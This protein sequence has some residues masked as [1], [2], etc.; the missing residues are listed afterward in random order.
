MRKVL[1][2]RLT[3]GPRLVRDNRT[4][5]A[6]FINAY[7]VNSYSIL[8]YG[9]RPVPGFDNAS[10]FAALNAD[11]ENG[12]TILI[13]SGTYETSAVWDIP[14]LGI[15]MLGLGGRSQAS[16]IKATHN[17]GPVIRATKRSFHLEGVLLTSSPERYAGGTSGNYG[18]HIAPVDSPAG[19]ASQPILIDVMVQN[20]PS[21]GIVISGQ[22]P[23]LH[24]RQINCFYNLGHG[25]V[26]D[27]GT[28]TNRVNRDIDPGIIDLN[29]AQ[30]ID[31]GGHG[32]VLGNPSQVLPP[33]RIQATNL[34]INDNAWNPS[35][36]FTDHQAYVNAVST[37]ISL[38]AFGNT[39]YAR[40][41]LGNG[42]T[43]SPREAPG[44]GLYLKGDNLLLSTPRFVNL[45]SSVEI[46][47]S[48]RG[49]TITRPRIYKGG[50]T[51]NQSVAV[52]IP[53]NAQ[54][55]TVDWPNSLRFHA[56]EYVVQA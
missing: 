34:E 20:Q 40:S 22:S 39:G 27:D 5:T 42:K 37:E 23:Y 15:H 10:A 13:P 14:F 45:T 8:E 47:A 32:F 7:F 16:V 30:F 41:A 53:A 31:N 6:K 46:G 51:T 38:S 35:V 11:L 49:I 24:M 43:I 55:I 50:Y 19:S 36:R 54:D 1:N 52:S 3:A 21:H 25:C 12:A 28:I 44:G 48:S 17:A 29:L 33:F 2:T 4:D 26:I 56:D 18:L 9:A